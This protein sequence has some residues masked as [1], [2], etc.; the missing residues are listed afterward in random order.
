[1]NTHV[2]DK[3]MALHL[4]VNIWSARKKLSPED[5]AQGAVLP[6]DD[7]A[8]LGSKKICDPEELRVFGMLKS[9]A[10]S[11][12]D[13]HGL[14]FLGGWA[15]AED[16]AEDIVR[17]LQQIE[18]DFTQ[19]KD[20]FLTSY[21]QTIQE[22]IDK[23]EGWERIIAGSVVSADYVRSRMGFSWKLYRIQPPDPADPLTQGLVQEVASLGTTLFGEISK[24]AND[25]W[26]QSFA[27]KTEITRKALSPLKTIHGKLCGLSFVEPR[28][29]PVADLIATVLSSLP[30]KGPIQGADLI[31]L[32][33]LVSLLRDSEALALHGQRLIAG[34]T[35]QNVL[36]LLLEDP[37]PDRF[38]PQQAPQAVSNCGLW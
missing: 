38:V 4:D 13:R 25:A 1:M 32:Q 23:H 2:I 30:D 3:L 36:D 35:S 10:V 21:D 19:A 11:L 24:M 8:S 31:M 5:F 27:G 20:R 16:Q 22:W 18:R 17:S 28:V 9:R 34:T 15:I 33:G 12:L 26:L 29:S 6:P 14:R 7:L 37:V